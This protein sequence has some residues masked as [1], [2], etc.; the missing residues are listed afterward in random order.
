[1]LRVGGMG[2]RRETRADDG[3]VIYGVEQKLPL[4]GKPQLARK[5][6]EAEVAAGQASLDYQ[7]QTLRVELSKAAFQAS[8]TSR[9]VTLGYEDL[10]WL[11][12]LTARVEQQYS[13]GQAS[14]FDL[15][16]AQ[17]ARSKRRDQLRTDL[18]KLEHQQLGLNRLLGRRLDSPW[19]KLE[20]PA[21]AAPVP[22]TPRLVDY[23]L[24]FEPKL[25]LLRQEIKK[26]EAVIQATRRQQLPDIN[27][28]VEGRTFTGDGS[29][30]S[31]TVMLSLNF[32]WANAGKYRSDLQREQARL[33]AARREALLYQNEIIPRSEQ[34]LATVHTAWEAGRGMFTDVLETR[35]ML[36]ESRLMFA[37]AVAE[38][39]SLLSEL[40][41][42]CGAGDF[43]A[44][45]A[46]SASPILTPPP[47]N[48]P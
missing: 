3:D 17:N 38:Q 18:T 35:R 26:A 5:T 47:A 39:Y 45:Q 15:L 12:V 24:Q 34:G 40:V 7:F 41:L 36:V 48:Q 1:M 9:T 10:A 16:R 46:I 19:P 2:A 32:P 14:Q 28:G 22:Y 29:F 42:C 31:G 21:L 37:R 4:F 11:D 43:E 20:L 6:S 30:R 44:L 33:D 27:A 23:A 25:K 13:V 8:L